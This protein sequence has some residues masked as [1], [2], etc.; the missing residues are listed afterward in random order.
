MYD[1]YW[2]TGWIHIFQG[3]HTFLDINLPSLTF[4]DLTWHGLRYRSRLITLNSNLSEETGDAHADSGM[5]FIIY[6]FKK[7]VKKLQFVLLHK[8]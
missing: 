5:Y 7:D 8:M 1:L 4:K 2:L 6:L 3:F